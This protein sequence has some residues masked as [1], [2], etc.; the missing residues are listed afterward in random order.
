M[1]KEIQGFLL[2]MLT[3]GGGSV[4]IAYLLFQWLGQKWIENKFAER[5]E[6]LRYQQALEIQRLRVE[7][8]SMLSGT[9]KLQ[10]K[11]FSILPEAWEK[12]DEAKGL[13]SWLV[14]PMQQ[15]ADVSRM[16]SMQLEEFLESTEL[17]ESH[18]NEIK[19][20]SDKNEVYQNA[21]FWRRLS[22][23]KKAC[24]ELQAYIARN[25]IFLPDSLEKKFSKISDTFWHALTS[26]EVGY[27]AQDWKMQNE[28]WS[29]IQ[30]EV[31]PL[32]E[33]IKREIQTRLKSHAK[34]A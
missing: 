14:S 6:Q 30:E 34:S 7:I 31:T 28:G 4:V 32:Y 20:S 24:S 27:E 2:Q 19:N 29:K 15:Y 18:K 8:D 10:E 25:G 22:K 3:Y 12:L 23:V 21:E 9:I 5:L 1:N 13:V 16:S 17:S 11:D 26:K 33:E